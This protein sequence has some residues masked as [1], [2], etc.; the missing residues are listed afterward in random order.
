MAGP[1]HRAA[2]RD[3]GETSGSEHGPARAAE[4]AAGPL[5]HAMA[6]PEPG[7]SSATAAIQRVASAG[8]GAPLDDPQIE[9]GLQS[10]G[11]GAPL[12]GALRRGLE[13]G[14]GQP[15]GGV[16]VHADAHADA[17]ARS[18]HAE[19]FTRGQ[20]IFFRS[21]AHDPGSAAGLHLLTH[22][23]VHTVQ[24]GA[25]AAG[26]GAAL[27]VSE[28]GDGHEREAERVADR[29]APAISG[30]SGWDRLATGGGDMSPGT[31]SRPASGGLIQRAIDTAASRA[32]REV[33]DVSKMT[34]AQKVEKIYELQSSGKASAFNMDLLWSSLGADELATARA[35]P[36]LFKQ[37]V[38]ITSA[39]LGH[40][41]FKALKEKFK[42]DV[43][44]TALA[45][46][47]SNRSYVAAEMEKLGAAEDPDKPLTGRQE[48]DLH[49]FQRI[50]ALL[51]RCKTAIA[52]FRAVPVGYNT[53]AI[54]GPGQRTSATREVAYFDPAGPPTERGGQ[55]NAEAG[56]AFKPWEEV[57]RE[58]LRVA[59]LK[60]ALEERSPAAL[61]LGQEGDPDKVAEADPEV[62]RREL[63]RGLTAM[64]RR[65]D[66]AVP[67]VGDDLSY[68]DFPPIHEALFAGQ[69]APSG[70][71]W[72]DPIEQ[73]VAKDQVSDARLNHLLITLGVSTIGAALFIFAEMATLGWATVLLAAGGL[74]ASG[75]QAIYSWDKYSDLA[76]AQAATVRPEL[77]IVSKEDVDSALLDAI[78]DTA[79]V[80]LDVAGAI[81]GGGKAG[82]YGVEMLAAAEKGAVKNAEVALAGVTRGAVGAGA[83]EKAVAEIGIEGA[84]RAS[85]KSAS[86]LAEIVGRDT[87]LGKK[88]LA[89]AEHGAKAAEAAEK[90][91]RLAQLIADGTVQAGEVAPIILHSV[92][93]FGY[94]GT[95]RRAGGWERLMGVPGVGKGPLGQM[96]ETWRVGIL[97]ELEAFLAAGGDQAAEA[98]RTGTR[99]A[100]SDLDVQVLADAA[101]MHSERA[102]HWLSAR[103]GVSQEEMGTLLQMSVFI[104]PTRAHVQDVIK[105]LAPELRDQIAKKQAGLARSLIFGA[106]I[107]AAKGNQALIEEIIKEARAAGLT[108]IPKFKALSAAERLDMARRIDQLAMDL[109]KTGDPKLIDEISSLEAMIGAS[110]PDAYVGSG[111]LLWVTGRDAAD[112]AAA[113]IQVESHMSREQRV[114][115]ALSE[116]K[117]FDKAISKLPAPGKTASLE[118]IVEAL[119]DI[120]KHGERV[121][122]VLG[123]NVTVGA[124][125][126]ENLGAQLKELDGYL[127]LTLKPEFAALK[128][129]AK[130]GELVGRVA[131]DEAGE[132]ARAH[133]LLGQLKT[134]SSKAIEALVKDAS[135]LN[136]PASEVEKLMYWTRLDVKLGAAADHLSYS[137]AGYFE[138]V[139][140]AVQLGEVASEASE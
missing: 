89:A 21:G 80:F 123:G 81:K 35:D 98:V 85:G 17:L 130:S 82:K 137:I 45:Y 94:L 86:E 70:T 58:Y 36:G 88:L 47:A 7:A 31:G 40:E 64:T 60:A 96:F 54:E 25:G 91:P 28:P 19:A 65:I 126:L 109:K 107:E 118:E 73:A 33:G 2:T 4:P 30:G 63:G 108:E 66:T 56:A 78:L 55:G 135:I 138:G 102:K 23:V 43:E 15:L 49:S 13:R 113:G 93:Q 104:D 74:A 16:R 34:T 59:A 11:A 5:W 110:N 114:I 79:F 14:L 136:L 121:T 32:A 61:F 119:K 52:G 3:S 72:K 125:Q 117:F 53:E 71:N 48:Q 106:R 133:S 124:I 90:L 1:G 29:V 92:D 62:A 139:H 131:L 129:A 18:L 140:A 127:R 37:S 46:L 76:R 24:Q 103:L 41:P 39:I 26:S 134:Q 67:L 128:D 44:G 68:I 112:L 8:A 6:T 122:Q 51:G 99:A 75:G 22:E 97:H 69:P 111:V 9:R 83:V 100:T 50:A 57:N 105:G 87:P 77:A 132:L 10:A 95:L 42:A 38:A 101:A 20:D 12:P 115:A 120:G 116:G 84:Q 27:T